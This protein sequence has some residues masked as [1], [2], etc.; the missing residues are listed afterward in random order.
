MLAV[1]VDIVM[2]RMLVLW[3]MVGAVHRM[4]EIT[5]AGIDD[6]IGLGDYSPERRW[7]EAGVSERCS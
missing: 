7:R 6:C 5:A 3:G 4:I 2:G 1:S